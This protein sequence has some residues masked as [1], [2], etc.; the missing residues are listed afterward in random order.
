MRPVKPTPIGP[1]GTG[2]QLAHGGVQLP[3][4]NDGDW[5]DFVFAAAPDAK[6]RKLILADSPA[7]LY[8]WPGGDG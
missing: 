8:G 1:R 5:L 7:R 3:M 6:T 4:S 2:Q